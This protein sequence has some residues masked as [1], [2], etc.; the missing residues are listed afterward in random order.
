MNNITSEDKHLRPDRPEPAEYMLSTITSTYGRRQCPQT[1]PKG[2]KRFPNLSH[3]EVLV[4]LELVQRSNISDTN[5]SARKPTGGYHPIEFA[6]PLDEDD[7]RCRDT[8]AAREAH[9]F[10]QFRTMA[11]RRGSDRGRTAEN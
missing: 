2:R 7:L 4:V 5:P 1:A 11:S 6:E 9:G 10:M 3:I 8:E